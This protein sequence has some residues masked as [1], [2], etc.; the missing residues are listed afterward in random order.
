MHIYITHTRTKNRIS[1]FDLLF[2]RQDKL[3]KILAPHAELLSLLLPRKIQACRY[4]S[5]MEMSS[6]LLL[7]RWLRFELYQL[8]LRVF[9]IFCS[10]F[11]V[12]KLIRFE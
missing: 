1:H 5:I 11:H 7:N 6:R 12:I 2:G 9:C 10:I 4:Q 8:L 3:R